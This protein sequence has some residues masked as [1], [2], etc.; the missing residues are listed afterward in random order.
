MFLL[1]VGKLS[2]LPITWYTIP[3]DYHRYTERLKPDSDPDRPAEL[4]WGKSLQLSLFDQCISWA[5]TLHSCVTEDS[6]S[7][8]W[9]HLRIIQCRENHFCTLF[10]LVSNANFVLFG[11]NLGM[12]H[13]CKIKASMHVNIQS[14][15]Q[16]K[17]VIYIYVTLSSEIVPFKCSSCLI[18]NL[19]PSCQYVLLDGQ[20]QCKI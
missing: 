11:L 6:C 9:S 1:W 7:W 16:Y 20:E 3:C 10:C 2:I 4:K 18:P 17:C 12:V 13:A 8:S 19:F 15:I 5:K 14:Y